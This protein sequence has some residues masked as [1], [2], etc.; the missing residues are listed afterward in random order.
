MER[1]RH[2]SAVA[3]STVAGRVINVKASP[4]DLIGDLRVLENERM[5]EMTCGEPRDKL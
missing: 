5:A 1:P 2:C 3:A 4:N